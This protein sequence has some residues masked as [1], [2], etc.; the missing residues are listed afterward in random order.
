[1]IAKI[2]SAM[3]L[4]L[5][6]TSVQPAFAAS[7]DRAFGLEDPRLEDLASTFEHFEGYWDVDLKSLQVNR[8]NFRHGVKP[9]TIKNTVKQLVYVIRGSGAN[10]PREVVVRKLKFSEH[11]IATAIGVVT[12]DTPDA[13][14][15][16]KSVLRHMLSAAL[17]DTPA[18]ELYT[19]ADA[20]DI[21]GG[22]SSLAV[23]AKSTLQIL[24][25]SSC[26]AE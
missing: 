12:K 11:N 21:Y 6:L 10:K 24:L 20:N 7:F 9:T 13:T 8:V 17:L 19:I 22:C 23:V 5:T 1:M 26:W 18:S 15:Q 2:A 16:D 3:V 4:L 25:V 14:V